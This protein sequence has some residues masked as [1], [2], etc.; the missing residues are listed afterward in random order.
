M[1]AVKKENMTSTSDMRCTSTGPK[2]EVKQVGL[3][4]GYAVEEYVVLRPR[5]KVGEGT[6]IKCAAILGTGVKIG[7]NCFIGPQAMLLHKT[8]DGRSEPA[9]IEDNV[10]IGAGSIIMPGVKICSGTIIG[11]GSLVNKSITNPGTYV[12]RPCRRI[13]SKVYTP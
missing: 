1:E 10:F 7:K 6:T 2:Y 13:S 12:G 9:E 8:P 5:V 11:A 3:G 4:P